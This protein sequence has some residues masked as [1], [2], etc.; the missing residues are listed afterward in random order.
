MHW[1]Q[2]AY[3]FIGILNSGHCLKDKK[4]MDAH[5]FEC[6]LSSDSHNEASKPE[7]MTDSFTMLDTNGPKLTSSPMQLDIAK[8]NG[9]CL[10]G[11]SKDDDCV[12][13][14][15][16]DPAAG[17]LGARDV[18]NARATSDSSCVSEQLGVLNKDSIPTT[19]D[20]ELYDSSMFNVDQTESMSKDVCPKAHKRNMPLKNKHVRIW[21]VLKSLF[22]TNYRVYCLI[23]VF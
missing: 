14:S 3:N 13:D 19:H 15:K 21:H 12:S 10:S 5:G 23:Q 20:P 2:L 17:F 22:S 7:T 1:N 11:P 8:V 6:P 18:G 9:E 4:V 16:A